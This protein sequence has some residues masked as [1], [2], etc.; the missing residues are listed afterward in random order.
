MSSDTTCTHCHTPFTPTAHEPEFCCAGCRFVNQ[1]LIGQGLGTFYDLQ[2]GKAGRP[3]GDRPFEEVD[4]T[5]L[6]NQITRLH[7]LTPTA[8]Q[9]TLTLRISGVTCVGCVWLIEQLFLE[10][11]GAVRATVF[12]A[13][14]EAEFTFQ[15]DPETQPNPLLEL[16]RDLPR[17]GYVLEDPTTSQILTPESRK[18]I[19][20]LGL[21]AAF[22]MNTMAFSLPRYLGMTQDFPFARLFDLIALLSATLALLVGG[23]YFFAKALASLRLRLI[24]ID[25][26]IALGLGLAYLGSLIGWFTN[27]HHLIYFDFVAVFTFLM[28][29]GR[30]LH[31]AASERAQNQ[32]QGQTALA[33]EATLTDGSSKPLQSILKNDL[34]LIPPGQALPVSSLLT[35]DPAEFSLAWMTGEPDPRLFPTGAVI[36]AGAIP[37]SSQKITVQAVE[38]YQDSVVERLTR[39]DSR[40]EGSRRSSTI[41]KYYL[42]AV[43]VIGLTT[44]IGWT[45]AGLPPLLALQR[46]ISVF[47]ISCPCAIGVAIPLT[48]RRASSALAKLGVFIQNHEI[49]PALLRIKNLIFDKTGTLTLE[50][51]QLTSTEPLTQLTPEAKTALY[52][53]TANSLHPLSRTLFQYLAPQFTHPPAPLETTSLPA[54]GTQLIS[55]DHTWTLGKPG[56]R[57]QDNFSPQTSE[58]LAC[59][60]ARDHQLIATFTFRETLRP[61]TQQALAHLQ[62]SHHL[63]ILSG[64]QATR[65]H[66]LAQ[67][68][69]I[70]P[71]HAHGNLSP[72][73][74][75]TLV[76]SLNPAL[77]LGDGINDTLAFSR[78]TLS[79]TPVA[80]RSLLDRRSDF[81]FTCPGL[82]FLPALFSMARWR[83]QTVA[84]IFTFTISY[85][86]TAITACVLGYMTPLAAAILMPLSSLLSLLIA[87]R[88]ISPKK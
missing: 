41:L 83:R 22:A 3:V 38:N 34:L 82:A 5:W 76:T 52:H 65:V 87:R 67:E 25:L 64:D 74:K 21:S 39:E 60:L 32:L 17:Y 56:W 44:G 68:L 53:L 61:R 12:P 80:D 45:L 57:G 75:A 23:T 14:A 85:N 9:H 78:A 20:R 2:D 13:S 46:M 88:R 4:L 43:L 71:D 77:Y 81:L 16:A 59:E 31:L 11:T 29:G 36:P 50:N 63:H 86:I 47:I 73:Q 15:A 19:P 28:L 37:L 40:H 54:L 51:P 6:E 84:L 72:D 24:H 79:G 49:W 69:G 70:P 33:A 62:K 35:S 66:D 7:Q 55:S 26:P 48:D 30:Y 18:L 27:E 8:T 1:M 10:K 42:A 58:T